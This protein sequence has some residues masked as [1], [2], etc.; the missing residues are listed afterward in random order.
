MKAD[1]L[2]VYGP[3]PSTTAYSIPRYS[4]ILAELVAGGFR[5]GRVPDEEARTAPVHAGGFFVARGG[6]S[7]S[8]CSNQRSGWKVGLGERT[9]CPAT[10]TF[11]LYPLDTGED[12]ACLGCGTIM[13]VSGTRFGKPTSTC[14]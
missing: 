4:I 2:H 3:M 7:G 1:H 10:R 14:C 6:W 8:P 5:S 13:K 11:L 12:P 9:L